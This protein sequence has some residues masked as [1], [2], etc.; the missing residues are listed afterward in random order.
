MTLPPAPKVEPL[1]PH[2]D[3]AAFS[4]GQPALDSYLRQQAS[5]D[6]KRRIARVFVAVGDAPATIAGYYSLSAASFARSDLPPESAKKLPHYPVP[7][8]II[9]RLAVDQAYQRRG[10][11]KFLLLDAAERVLHASA[12]VAVYAIIVDAKDEA[13][14]RFYERYGFIAFPSM[15]NRLF[16][17]LSVFQESGL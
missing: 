6:A 7:A 17:P 14:R 8:A 5:Q 2:H 11:G 12:A 15:E 13:A 4:C 1:G 9:G 16:L 3:R 10:Y